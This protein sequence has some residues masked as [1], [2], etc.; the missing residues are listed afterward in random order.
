VVHQ[1]SLQYLLRIAVTVVYMTAGLAASP[2]WATDSTSERSELQRLIHELE[3]IEV[4]IQAA[5]A[6]AISSQRI[7]FQY[8]W[9]RSDLARVKAGIREY[10][11]TVPL[12]P[13][14]VPPLAGDYIR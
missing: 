5:E 9:L 8:Q 11:D 12:A 3:Q 13:R 7:H 4:R 10:L 2:V 6:S 1:Y 14:S